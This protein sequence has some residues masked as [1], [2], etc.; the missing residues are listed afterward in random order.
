MAPITANTIHKDGGTSHENIDK[1]VCLDKVRVEVDVS[2]CGRDGIVYN[3]D[4]TGYER[5][6]V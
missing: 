1:Y 6:I 2:V 3:P 5:I 4:K